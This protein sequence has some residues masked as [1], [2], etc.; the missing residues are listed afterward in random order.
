MNKPPDEI[1]DPVMYATGCTPEGVI[2]L[3]GIWKMW[4]QEGFPIEMAHI[5][6]RDKGCAVDWFEAMCDA[7]IT[8]NCPALMR[9]IGEFL[10]EDV[11]IKLKVGFMHAI[12]SGRTFE[13][14]VA[15]KKRNGRAFRGF[16]RS[17]GSSQVKPPD[18]P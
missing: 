4:E 18:E 14:I 1:A 7:S 8:N 16:V 5:F 13:E 11:I 10:P 12:K 6:C 2:L 17:R 9:Q 3:G 15:E